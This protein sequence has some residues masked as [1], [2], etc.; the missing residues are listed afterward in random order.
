MDSVSREG[1]TRLAA[2]SDRRV[3]DGVI[4]ETIHTR[5]LSA[6]IGRSERGHDAPALMLPAQIAE[7]CEAFVDELVS[8]T[9]RHQEQRIERLRRR[10]L[11]SLGLL[12]GVFAPAAARIGVRWEEDSISFAE[13]TIAMLELQRWLRALTRE[14]GEAGARSYGP[15]PTILFAAPETEQHRFALSL[16]AAVFRLHGW[17]AVEAPAVS[18][19]KLSAMLAQTHYDAFGLSIGSMATLE[20]SEL[21]LE[22]FRTASMNKDLM[23]MVGGPL[24]TLNPEVIAGLN[25]DVVVR[26][27]RHAAQMHAPMRCSA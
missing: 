27:V 18:N 11:D 4:E 8:G 2:D 17:D 13:T 3:T 24:V 19:A 26:D 15:S 7:E 25:A 14:T 21:D 9:R 1:P 5:V 12:N 10:G 20:T 6:L 23:I 22:L 16:A